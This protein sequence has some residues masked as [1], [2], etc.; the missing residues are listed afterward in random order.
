MEGLEK[1]LAKVRRKYEKDQKKLYKDKIVKGL[2]E[3]YRKLKIKEER[4]KK[5]EDEDEDADMPELED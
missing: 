3:N 2:D 4:R 1:V 5:K